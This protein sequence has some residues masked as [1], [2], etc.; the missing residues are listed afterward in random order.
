MLFKEPSLTGFS[1]KKAYNWRCENVSECSYNVLC[2]FT[3]FGGGWT[4]LFQRRYPPQIQFNR[5]MNEYKHGFGVIG[6]DLEF[7]LGLDKMHG[8]TCNMNCLNELLIVFRTAKEGKTG[9]AR[10]DWVTVMAETDQYKLGLGP[11]ISN[12]PSMES[13][14]LL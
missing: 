12:T 10:Y 13:R 14:Y 5:T 11:L 7:W 8:L 6:K 1:L 9:M 4:I 2:D 3:L